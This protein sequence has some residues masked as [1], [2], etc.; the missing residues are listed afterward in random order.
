M[1]KQT[2]NA[3]FL[4]SLLIKFFSSYRIPHSFT[5]RVDARIAN[6]N[7]GVFG[8]STIRDFGHNPQVSRIPRRTASAPKAPKRKTA[9]T[10]GSL[11]I[12]I[13]GKDE[14]ALTMERMCQGL[15]EVSRLL[16]EHRKSHRIKRAA[17]YLTIID[18]NGAP[19][20]ITFEDELTIYPYQAVA[21]DFES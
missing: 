21:D 16:L 11:V 5:I 14:A 13:S 1:H 17:L 12:K 4:K 20:R 10:P 8:L 9:A 15:Y 18:E 7:T 19:S 6:P 2:A 3:S